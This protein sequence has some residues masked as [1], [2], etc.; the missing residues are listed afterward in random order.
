MIWIDNDKDTGVEMAI[1]LSGLHDLT[2]N[3]FIL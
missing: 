2:A 1:R 3:D